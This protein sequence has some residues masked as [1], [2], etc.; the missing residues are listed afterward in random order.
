[1]DLLNFLKEK[2]PTILLMSGL[3]MTAIWFFVM[4]H[5]NLYE[6]KPFGAETRT[7]M[8]VAA[9][10]AAPLGVGFLWLLSWL[11]SGENPYLSKR[12][13][14]AIRAKRLYVLFKNWMFAL[15]VI[16]LVISA[17]R[18]TY[19][20]ARASEMTN[21]EMSY[22]EQRTWIRIFADIFR[23]SDATSD[24]SEDSSVLIVPLVTGSESTQTPSSNSNSSDS[25]DDS[26][27]ITEL[28]TALA[29]LLAYAAMF[30]ILIYYFVLVGLIFI[31]P[32]FFLV[33]LLCLSTGMIALGVLDIADGPNQ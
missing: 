23:V 10:I 9:W 32:N 27:W 7:S 21:S 18:I 4:G 3:L 14:A 30:L 29:P 17:P 25:D 19:L 33:T 6:I 15:I 26:D 8:A 22:Y 20:K 11:G 31:Y 12:S 5:Y 1:M 16:T 24:H 13:S 28:F 2:R